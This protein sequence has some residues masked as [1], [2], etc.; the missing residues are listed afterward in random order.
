MT[1]P[2][3]SPPVQ[4]PTDGALS[5]Q[6]LFKLGEI[7]TDVAVIKT[8]MKDVQ[9]H[10]SRIRVLEAARFRIAGGA[11]VLGTLAGAGAGWVTI[12]LSRR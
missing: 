9:D 8:E 10:E 11:A 7:S 4:Q 6:I 12:I 3:P 5:A 2:L 1:T